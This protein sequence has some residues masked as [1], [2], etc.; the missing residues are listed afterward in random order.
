MKSASAAHSSPS[1]ARAL[2]GS[3]IR[4]RR[5]QASAPLCEAEVQPSRSHVR[6]SCGWSSR[7]PRSRRR[8]RGVSSFCRAI[9]SFRSSGLG[10]ASSS[11]A[12]GVGSVLALAGDRD[13]CPSD[14]LKVCDF[15]DLLRL[16]ATMSVLYRPAAV[17]NRPPTP[18]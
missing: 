6:T 2:P 15:R 7:V 17:R 16:Q 5:K 18:G 14:C 10:R 9:L 1:C 3:S 11:P 12:F 4:A 13:I 8:A